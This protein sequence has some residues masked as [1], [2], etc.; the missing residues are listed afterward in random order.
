MS[1]SVINFI[2]RQDVVDQDKTEITRESVTSYHGACFQGLSL[3]VFFRFSLKFQTIVE[4]EQD[5][6]FISRLHAGKLN[7]IPW[8]VNV[9]CFTNDA[10]I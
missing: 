10:L 9:T 7:I 4:K 6:N 1:P 2:D 3:I 5:A 8:Y